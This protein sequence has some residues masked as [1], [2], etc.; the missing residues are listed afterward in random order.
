MYFFPLGPQR[1][2]MTLSEAEWNDAVE[3]IPQSKSLLIYF[4]EMYPRAA[5]ID[6][7]IQDETDFKPLDEAE[8]REKVVSAII[9]RYYQSM[10]EIFVYLEELDIR[11]VEDE[12]EGQEVEIPYYRFIDET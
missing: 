6:E 7:F 10:A 12:E 8:G 9:Y 2:Y 3:V 1:A 5:T 11:I 4:K